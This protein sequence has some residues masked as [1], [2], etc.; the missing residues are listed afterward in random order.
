MLEI[1]INKTL[2]ARK[3]RKESIKL[4]NLEFQNGGGFFIYS[5]F[6]FLFFT[7]YKNNFIKILNDYVC[8][9]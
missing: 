8:F 3:K 6:L 5:Y 4:L 2:K 7:D 1:L 9:Y